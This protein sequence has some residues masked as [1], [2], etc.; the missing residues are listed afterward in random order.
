MLIKDRIQYLYR[1]SCNDNYADFGK[2]K[3]YD[4]QI[5][6]FV[7]EHLKIWYW[8][9]PYKVITAGQV[10]F[11]CLYEHGMHGTDPDKVW[12]ELF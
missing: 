2:F 1:K 10:A 3:I 4:F 5:A 7:I 12:E 11:Q 9:N 8:L 6:E